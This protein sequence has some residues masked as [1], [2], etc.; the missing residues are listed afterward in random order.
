[1]SGELVSPRSALL[2]GHL[3]ECFGSGEGKQRLNLCSGAIL[4]V[5]AVVFMS[6]FQVQLLLID[7]VGG[8]RLNQLFDL[9]VLR[10]QDP[11]EPY[12]GTNDVTY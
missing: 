2:P 3:T 11:Q 6:G 8:G 7:P 12:N 9:R 10:W 1:M 4:C 5:A